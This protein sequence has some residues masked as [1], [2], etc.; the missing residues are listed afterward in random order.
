MDPSG[1]TSSAELVPLLVLQGHHLMEHLGLLNQGILFPLPQMLQAPP[2][3]CY[4]T[5]TGGMQE[6]PPD[7]PWQASLQPLQFSLVCFFLEDFFLNL[8][9]KLDKSHI[10]SITESGNGQF[11]NTGVTSIAVYK[12]VDQFIKQFR[13]RFFCFLTEQLRV[14]ENVLLGSIVCALALLPM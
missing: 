7:H 8:F 5:F 6:S 3:L 4:I 11:V 12:L 1:F 10:C 2:I 14:C 13:N 9:D